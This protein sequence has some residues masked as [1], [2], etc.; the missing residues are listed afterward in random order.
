[1]A[2][3]TIDALSR[4]PLLAEME[5]TQLERL[6]R[7][8]R[9]RRFDAAQVVTREGEEGAGFFVIVEGVAAVTV[10]GETRR[11]LGPGDAF[12]EMA[13]IDRGPRS[14]TVIAETGL[15]CLALSPWDFR[16]FVEENPSVAWSL[17]ET[18]A[19]RLRA[20]DAHHDH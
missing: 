7:S 3:D 6:A 10:R 19:A 13:L 16:A 5:R 12:G 11:E 4:V 2:V 8:F 18:M 9:E 1:M 20:A 17:L 14:A 15:L